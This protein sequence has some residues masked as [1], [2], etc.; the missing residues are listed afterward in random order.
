[1]RRNIYAT[2]KLLTGGRDSTIVR[3]TRRMAAFRTTRYRLTCL[4]RYKT[5]FV[6][7]MGWSYH[8][9]TSLLALIPTTTIALLTFAAITCSLCWGAKVKSLDKGSD[10]VLFDPTDSLH[11]VMA[12]SARGLTGVL[13]GFSPSGLRENEELR[14]RIRLVGD[15]G[16]AL[17][18]DDTN[19]NSTGTSVDITE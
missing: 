7:T 9:S 10:E 4:P 1:M 8:S 16:W 3:A 15:G 6:D 13:K 2:G 11:V 5:M 14:V 12:S 17:L 19:L 18:V